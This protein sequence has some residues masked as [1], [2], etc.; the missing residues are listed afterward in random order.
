MHHKKA[1]PETDQRQLH[2]RQH[3]IDSGENRDGAVDGH[4]A[5][6]AGGDESRRML[7]RKDRVGGAGI[8]WFAIAAV[9]RLVDWTR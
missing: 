3:G 7:E 4:A 5:D 6:G 8:V 1:K 2:M 9:L